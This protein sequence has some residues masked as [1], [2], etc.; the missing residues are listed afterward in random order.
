MEM[1]IEKA[2]K[3]IDE[4]KAKYVATVQKLFRLRNEPG[5]TYEIGEETPN[6]PSLVPSAVRKARAS[7]PYPWHRPTPGRYEAIFGTQP[8][9][10]SVVVEA[11]TGAETVRVCLSV[12]DVSR[13]AADCAACAVDIDPS[14]ALCLPLPTHRV[15]HRASF[16]DPHSAFADPFAA[17]LPCPEPP[18]AVD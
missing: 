16:A 1:E 14:F 9:P 4:A 15:P 6:C 7:S 5:L 8:P 17:L 18:S 2:W 10:Q 3:K 11:D 12:V 13:E